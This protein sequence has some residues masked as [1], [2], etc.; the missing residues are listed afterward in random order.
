MGFGKT[1]VSEISLPFF[2]KFQYLRKI[3]PVFLKHGVIS[4]KIPIQKGI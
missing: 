1:P 4:R 2:L 3:V